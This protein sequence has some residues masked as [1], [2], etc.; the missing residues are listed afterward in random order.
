[1]E[2][3]PP[4]DDSGQMSPSGG[5]SASLHELQREPREISWVIF[6]G[7]SNARIQAASPPQP[8]PPGAFRDAGTKVSV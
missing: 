7:K 8:S 4:G 5:V 1:M 2:Q 6:Q 3:I